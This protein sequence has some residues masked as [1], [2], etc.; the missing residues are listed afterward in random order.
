MGDYSESF[1]LAVSNDKPMISVPQASLVLDEGESV[2]SVSASDSGDDLVQFQWLVV[3]ENAYFGL[4]TLDLPSLRHHRWRPRLK[5]SFLIRPVLST[6][7]T[8]FW[9]AHTVL[10]QI[11]RS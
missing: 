5:H 10:G 2:I 7:N 9:S 6:V 3:P 1:V 4:T 8:R 11:E